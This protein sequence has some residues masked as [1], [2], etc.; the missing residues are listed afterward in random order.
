MFGLKSGRGT[1]FTH[2]PPHTHILGCAHI[3][4]AAVGNYFCEAF[5]FD[6]SIFCIDCHTSLLKKII[7]EKQTP[8]RFTACR[9]Q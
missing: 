9:N 4:R 1:M 3:P 7:F 6:L 5:L 8:E 2:L